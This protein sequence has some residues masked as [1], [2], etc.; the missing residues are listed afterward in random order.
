MTVSSTKPQLN[1]DIW[2]GNHP[3]YKP[4]VTF[5]INN[6]DAVTSYVEG[7]VVSSDATG[8]FYKK[9]I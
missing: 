5:S 7:Y 1:V 8:N 4:A 6:S 3:F 2:S 9:L